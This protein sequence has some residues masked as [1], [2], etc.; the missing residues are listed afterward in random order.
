MDAVKTRLRRKKTN[1]L[2]I[3][4]TGHN[5]AAAGDTGNAPISWSGQ[6]SG[7][8]PDRMIET[9]GQGAGS[10]SGSLSSYPAEVCEPC[11]SQS[12]E[13]MLQYQEE[14]GSGCRFLHRW[15][16]RPDTFSS[17]QERR[18]F[19]C[20]WIKQAA[21]SCRGRKIRRRQIRGIRRKQIRKIRRRQTQ[22]ERRNGI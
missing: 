19:L 7:G 3:R 21:A 18:S 22:K 4:R 8:S 16:G 13:A 20:R 9:T 2:G 15:T 1:P 14:M 17:R 12:L 5:R 6:N 11:H 10:H